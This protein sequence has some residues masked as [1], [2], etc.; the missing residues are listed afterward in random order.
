M[1]VVPEDY[2]HELN[3]VNWML[4]HNSAIIV[5]P[6]EYIFL[7]KNLCGSNSFLIGLIIH[8]SMSRQN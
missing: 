1:L 3:Q 8:L 4:A 7:L 6:T 2:F 5:Q